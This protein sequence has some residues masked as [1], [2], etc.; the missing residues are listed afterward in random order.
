MLGK[1]CLVTG[2]TSGIGKATALGL[3]QQGATVVL[4]CRDLSKGERIKAEIAAKTKD[5]NPHLDILVADLGVQSSIRQLA[6]DFKAKYTYLHVLINNAGASFS[7]R[8]VSKDGL[9][10]NLALNHLSYFLLTNL[11]LAVLKTSTPARVIN[12]TSEAQ[13]SGRIN[14]A[15]LQSEIN[16]SEMRA[17]AQS[18]LA[19]VLFTYELARRLAGSGV[20]VNCVH[21]GAVKTN[22]ASESNSFFGTMNRLARPFELSP[23]QGAATSL[24]LATAPEV[25][26]VSGKYFIKKRQTNSSKQSYDLE[27]GWRLWE[28]SAQLTAL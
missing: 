15:D 8:L 13:S 5:Q 7:R 23:D 3:A 25:A 27:M 12:V 24:Y 11:L 1:V 17:Y 9:E 10:M 14:L 22:F 21:P 20:T 26:E 4:V 16:Y 28:V 19:N 2:S 18:K 6:A